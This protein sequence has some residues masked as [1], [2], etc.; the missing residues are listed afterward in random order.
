MRPLNAAYTP[1]I[2]DVIVGKVIE[3]GPKRWKIDA[4]AKQDSVLL[5]S[6]ISLPGG[7]QRRKSEADEMQMKTFF[8]KGEW[9]SAEVQTLYMDGAFGV[10]TRNY[11]YGK[12]INGTVVQVSPALIQ[13]SKSHF[14]VYDNTVDVILGMNGYVWVGNHRDKE[15]I[16]ESIDLYKSEIEKLSKAQWEKISRI[17]NC[18]SVLNCSFVT[19]S[20]PS[21]EYMIE[22]SRDICPKDILDPVHSVRLIENLR[23]HLTS[24]MTN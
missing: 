19:I 7:I 15:I 9:L 1:D 5:L 13:R 18:I 8:K 17:S 20:E 10:H 23:L 24:Q 16:A 11:K 4:N 21:I 12:L 6:S 14:H 3:V 22:H 2:G